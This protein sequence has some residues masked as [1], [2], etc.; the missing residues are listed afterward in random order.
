MDFNENYT[1]EYYEMLA[2]QY[3]SAANL[4]SAP[5]I[6]DFYTQQ[7]SELISYVNGRNANA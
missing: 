6:K 7:A 1:T 2:A 5:S 3:V 4:A